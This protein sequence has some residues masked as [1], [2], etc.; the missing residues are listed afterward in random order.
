MQNKKY[1]NE[2]VLTSLFAAIT[3]I[4]AFSPLGYI[5][6]GVIRA[7][8]VQIPVII[9]ALFCGP[10]RGAFLGFLF[11]FTSCLGGT[12]APTLTSFIFS[13]VIAASQIGVHG[14][15]YSTL[16]CFGPRIL[17]GVLPYFVYKGMH[18]ICKVKTVNFA[19]AGVIGSLTNTILV[20]GLI[21]L[22]YKEDYATAMGE[23]VDVILGFIGTTICV[24]GVIEAI[25]SGFIVSA[26]GNVLIKIKPIK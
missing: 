3:L 18:K 2:L 8:I 5:P 4:M 9:G 23:S 21:F 7:T 24:N 16:I 12:I 11:G 26:V 14:A 17:V 22:L 10:K 20:M 15:V 6:I 19:I 1:I 25:L 13:P